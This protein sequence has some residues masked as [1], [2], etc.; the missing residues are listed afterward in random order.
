MRKAT[1]AR[2]ILAALL[3]SLLLSS[4]YAPTRVYLDS[5]N[6]GVPDNLDYRNDFAPY[7]K[8]ANTPA[9]VKVDLWG[10]PLDADKDGVPDYLDK[11]PNTPAGVNVDRDGCPIDPTRPTVNDGRYKR[12][13]AAGKAVPRTSVVHTQRTR[14]V[15]LPDWEGNVGEIEV[16]T[17]AGSQKL[18]RAWDSTEV[19]KADRLPGKPVVMDEQ[20]VKDFFKDALD[21]QPKNPALFTIH[22]GS[23]SAEPTAQSLQAISE[24]LEA[25]RSRKANHVSVIGHTDTVA[26]GEFNR[27]LSQSRARSVAELLV[28]RGL[29]RAILDIK[30]YGEEKLFIETPDNVAEPLNRR[31]EIIVE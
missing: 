19:V 6:D 29:D 10:C 16:S 24:A 27:S 17:S 20:E 26:S 18:D 21:A 31:V 23:G 28:H 3:F 9:G 1:T 25:I 12:A 5:D 7:D 11:C 4:C 30:F 15:L 2:S 8:C 14:F 13:V 22:F